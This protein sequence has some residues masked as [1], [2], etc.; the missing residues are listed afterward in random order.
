MFMNIR[1][2]YIYLLRLAVAVLAVTAAPQISAFDLSLY[3]DTSALA[4]GRWIKV[5]VDRTGL[6]MLPV[7][8]LRRMGFS[9]PSRVRIHGYG[10]RRIDDI[11][12][13]TSYID[14]LPEAPQKL[15]D[16][17][18]VFYALGPDLWERSA[19]TPYYHQELSPYTTAGYYF[20]TEGEPATEIT[21]TTAVAGRGSEE[22]ATTVQG[23][24]QHEQD[25]VMATDAGPLMVGEDFRYT[26]SRSF[27]LEMPG[28]VAG[29]Q[30]WLECQFVA[31]HVGTNSLLSFIVNGT[32]VP[33]VSG[34]RITA[35]S[36]SHYVHASLGTT[37]HTFTPTEGQSPEVVKVDIAHSSQGVVQKAHLDYLTLNY[38]RSLE[39][40]SSGSIEFWANARALSL[41]GAVD[42][43]EIWDVTDPHNVAVVNT[44][45]A[46]GRLEWRPSSATMRSYV[47]WRP[48]ASLPSPSVVGT[49]AP[50]NLHATGGETDMVII[51]PRSLLRQG[52]RIAELHR[53]HDGYKVDV[54]D[55]EQVYNEFSSGCADVSG[56]R[57]YLKMLYDRGN[58]SGTPLRF[59][60]LLGRTTL[61]NRQLSSTT[62]SL[63]YTTMPAWVNRQPRQSMNDNDGL[64]TD[65]FIAMLGDGSGR[66]MGLDDLSVAVGRIPM[67]SDSDGSPIV[68]KLYQYV[69]SSRRTNWKNRIMVLAD[70]EDS[71][72]HLRQA[73]A[74]VRNFLATPGQQHI[75]NKV[76]LDA[77]L[78]SSGAYPEA[79][80]E[81]FRNLDEGTAWWFFTGH[82]NNH[83]W[84]G[85]NQLTYTDLNNLYLRNVPFVVASTCDFLRWDSETTSGGEIMY[86][87]RYGG[88]IG[89]VSAT[90]PV[91]ISDNGYYL[92][93]LGRALLRRDSE[94]RLPSAGEVY[95]RSKNDILD[96]RGNHVSNPNRLRFV[97]MGDPAMR[98]VTPDNIV[99]VLTIDGREVRLEDQVTIAAMSDA[100]ITGRVTSPDG[101]LLSDFNGVVYVDIY[102]ALTSVTTY[103]N[104]NGSEEVFDRHGDKIYAGSA[105]VKDG[106]FT[107]KVAMPQTVADNF[108]PATMS[109]YA[110]AGDSNTG[111][112]AVGACRDFYVYGFDEPETPDTVN[113]AIDAMYLNHS[114]FKSGD[115]VNSSPVLMASV[116]DNVGINLSNAGVGFQ[117]TVTI[118]GVNSLADVSSYYIPASDGSPSGTI[119]YPMENIAAGAHTLRLRVFDT[120]G[121]YADREIDFFVDDNVPPQI[122]DV[123]T[124]A[125]PAIDRANFYVTY[126]RPEAIVNI[127]VSVYDLMGHEL[128]TGSTTGLS[129]TNTSEPVTWDLTD[130][131]GRRVNRGIYIFRASISTDNTNYESASR[132]IAVSAQ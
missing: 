26:P 111:A 86:K 67:T 85:D 66:D 21:A 72:V 88:A 97:F 122:F 60:L 69:N 13:A 128:W 3:A 11:M 92:E 109:L 101:T 17:G 44:E 73:E 106:L 103:G 38:I 126:D 16:A 54:V 65:D 8:E 18:I 80:R 98:V 47:A 63:G 24:V 91:Y 84:T 115:R 121:N 55:V 12:T 116:S 105:V 130:N 124:D 45:T 20:I 59:A 56:L 6:Y 81:M 77:Y 132:R 89:M 46:G 64:T 7:A 75:I 5:S 51:A 33:A 27:T 41:G 82:A 79:R 57:K 42:G 52:E 15:T 32:E 1:S 83:S 22:A 117:M 37:R 29:T 78:R 93:A 23:R 53:V 2:L 9:D 108:R 90:R 35:T 127:R 76:Y 87:E 99:E 61:D 107:L 131:A 43:V 123:Y 100:T 118:D 39:M 94:G 120:S 125:C 110:A 50:Q 104:G 34:D 70:D 31:R 10:G 48:G 28:R 74:M 129:S 102:D 36:D 96:S 114:G 119:S 19:S 62:R 112:E 30:L 58:A 40:P 14:D 25:L 4:S 113:P 49:V 95:R 68:D 71:G